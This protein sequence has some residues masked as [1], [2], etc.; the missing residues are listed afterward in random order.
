LAF[1]GNGEDCRRMNE[2]PPLPVLLVEDDS[3]IAANIQ[4]NL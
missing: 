1:P 2:A 3:D 4:D